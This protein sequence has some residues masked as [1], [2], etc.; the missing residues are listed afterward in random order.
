[1]GRDCYLKL[2]F[3]STAYMLKGREEAVKPIPVCEFFNR[4]KNFPSLNMIQNAK[5]DM[6]VI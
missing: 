5:H 6:Q 4:I 2:L 3:P 1:M